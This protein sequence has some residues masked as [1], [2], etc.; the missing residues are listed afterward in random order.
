MDEKRITRLSYLDALP[1]HPPPE[2]LE[3]LSSYVMRQA[4]ANGIVEIRALHKLMGVVLNKTEKLGDYPH[5]FFGAV[6]LRT[7]CS[8][9]HLQATT[10]Y[11]AG[12][13]F[14]R[15]TKANALSRFFHGSLGEQL[16]Y[17]PSCLSS[18]AYYPLTWRFIALAG[19]DAHHCRLLDRCGHCGEHIPLF[20]IPARLGM[21]PKCENALFDCQAEMLSQQEREDVHK[22]TVDLEYLLSPQDWEEREEIARAIGWRLKQFRE[23]KRYTVEHIADVLTES[24]RTLRELERGTK[25]KRAP[26]QLYLRYIDY[27]DLTLQELCAQDFDLPT[28]RGQET[29][30]KQERFVPRDSVQAKR[31]QRERDLLTLAQKTVQDFR[32]RGVSFT[33]GSLC[34]E[35]HMAPQNLRNYPSIKSLFE[36]LAKEQREEQ[37]RQRQHLE[38]EL[39]GQVK[40]AAL[41]LGRG[42]QAISE[43]ILAAYL[44]RPISQLRR[45]PRVNLLLKQLLGKAKSPSGEFDESL[46]VDRMNNAIADM[47]AGGQI[48]TLKGISKSVGLSVH[49][50]EQLPRLKEML[51]QAAEDGRL[52]QRN[53]SQLRCQEIVER[54]QKVKEELRVS[55]Q[56]VSLKEFA[57]LVGLSPVILSRFEP[58]RQLLSSVVEEYRRDGPQR[59]QQRERELLEQVRQAIAHLQ[60]SGQ[61]VTQR[62]IGRLIG[63]SDASLIYYHGFKVLYRQVIEERRLVMEQQARQREEILLERTHE[64]IQQLHKQGER[65]T[66]QSIARMIGLSRNSLRK[67][68]RIDALFQELGE[69]RCNGRDEHSS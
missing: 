12:K 25:E 11:H 5:R 9:L 24:V 2:R 20:A 10:L 33:V 41:D 42:G 37:A 47:R 27:L 14:G 31:Q 32:G 55:G 54:I 53:Q 56:I 50:L 28:K 18:S 45:L 65:L 62:A 19:C 48:A 8:E 68:P 59:A 34:R 49:R 63:L 38:D 46:I 40:Q 36:E 60:E 52:R 21:C 44:Q 39:I 3:S 69:A 17:C 23:A 22:R 66:P 29:K 4:E 15:S 57:Q 51:R 58:V 13:K 26:F 30:P 16:R 67:Y 43:K 61:R 64:A 6:S 35:L 7:A 1:L